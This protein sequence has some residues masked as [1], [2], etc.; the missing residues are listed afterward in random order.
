MPSMPRFISVIWDNENFLFN[1]AIMHNMDANDED[2]IDQFTSQLWLAHGLSENTLASYGSDMRQ[3]ARFMQARHK[4]LVQADVADLQA[5]LA[6]LFTSQTVK[7]ST[8]SN[9]KI[10]CFKRFYQWLLQSNLRAD[11]P[12]ATLVLAIGMLLVVVRDML[13]GTPSESSET[14]VE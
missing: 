14:S 2:L 13:R 7:K 11:D 4:S 6:G 1:R 3:L 12:T 8:S 10:S 5:Y 9:R